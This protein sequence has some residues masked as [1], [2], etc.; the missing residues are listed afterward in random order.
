MGNGTMRKRLG[1]R[2]GTVFNLCENPPL[3]QSLNIE[4]NSTCNQSCVFCPFHGKYAPGKLFLTTM[5]KKDAIAL[6]DMA[7]ECGIGKKEIGFH[8]AGDVFLY[9]ELAEIVSYA[10]K[11]GYAYTF[12]TTNGALATPDRMKEVLDA[13]ID[14][15]RVSI[16]AVDREMYHELHGRDDF[17]KVFANLRYMHH[18]IKDNSLKVSTSVSCVITKKTLGIQEDFKKLFG[19]YVDDILFIPVVLQRLSC[20]EQ[21]IKDY[22]VIDDSQTEVKSDFI[23]PLLFDTMYINANLEVVPCSEA[24]DTNCVFYDLKQDFNL[25]NAWN[26]EKYKAYRKLFLNKE[27]LSDTICE[28]CTL[29][30]KGLERFSLE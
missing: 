24:Y 17:D 27:S 28:D 26:S 11:A 6:I 18:Y 22:Q 2:F 5:K 12:I 16:N 3:P 4:L 21:F 1:E 19:E 10:K 8:I 9:K 25:I 30:M 20:D 29:R 23:C 7:K 13:G 15:I 14:S